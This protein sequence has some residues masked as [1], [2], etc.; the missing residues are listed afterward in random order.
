MFQNA[1]ETV[2]TLYWSVAAQQDWQG[3]FSAA[4]HDRSTVG[5]FTE[6]WVMAHMVLDRGKVPKKKVD[7][8]S[9][10]ID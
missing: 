8:P 7:K 3:Q 9:V 10:S 2:Q 1:A 5:A 4:F 6:T